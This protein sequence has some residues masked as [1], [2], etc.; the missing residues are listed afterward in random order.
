MNRFENFSPTFVIR[1]PNMYYIGEK[2]KYETSM[3]NQ[4]MMFLK[5]PL[6]PGIFDNITAVASR[7]DRP[8]AVG[9]GNRQSEEMFWVFL[10]E[11]VCAGTAASAFTAFCH[12]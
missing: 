9:P 12:C 4:G 6:E 7:R 10:P 8:D 11:P 5:G 2:M 1:L 3:H